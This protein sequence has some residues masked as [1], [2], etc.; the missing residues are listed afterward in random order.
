MSSTQKNISWITYADE[1]GLH[2]IEAGV[3]P[4]NIG[5]I[6][7]LEKAGF[8]IEGIARKNVK[9]NGVWE[10]HQTLAILNSSKEEE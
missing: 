5:S 4:R 9:I 6:R 3:S 7:A 8:H 1:L 10:D 2:R